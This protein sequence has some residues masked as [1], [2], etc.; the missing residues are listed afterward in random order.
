MP[1]TILH[2]DAHYVAIDKPAG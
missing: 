2:Q 1:L